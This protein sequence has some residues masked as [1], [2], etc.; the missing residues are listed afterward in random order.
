[1]SM[2]LVVL[3]E[4]CWIYE[5]I[6]VSS[7]VW[8]YK[9]MNNSTIDDITMTEC[10]TTMTGFGKVWEHNNHTLNVIELRGHAE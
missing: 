6:Y 3:A 2:F 4:T 7:N 10:C 8:C 1:M 9:C 5:P